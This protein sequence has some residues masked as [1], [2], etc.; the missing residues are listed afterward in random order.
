MEGEALKNAMRALPR[1]EMDV[2]FQQLGGQRAQLVER[3]EALYAPDRLDRFMAI[4]PGGLEE[5]DKAIEL[6]DPASPR[7]RTLLVEYRELSR[8]ILAFMDVYEELVMG[9]L[10]H[11]SREELEMVNTNIDKQIALT[12]ETLERHP[13]DTRKAQDAAGTLR[14]AVLMKGAI[15]HELRKRFGAAPND[16]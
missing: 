15:R 1:V 9:D 8:I 2:Q 11:M 12:Q 16:E 6:A 7:E 3:L 10:R 14:L 13:D 5:I 4:R